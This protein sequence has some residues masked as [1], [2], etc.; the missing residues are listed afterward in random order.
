MSKYLSSC[1][2]V[3]AMLLCYSGCIESEHALSDPNSAELVPELMG[4]WIQV[5]PEDPSVW[6]IAAA[7]DGFPK[8]MHRL[9]KIENG[10]IEGKLFFVSNIGD[11]HYANIANFEDDLSLP[12]T[13]QPKQIKHYTLIQF[14]VKDGTAKLFEIEEA[15]IV[16]AIDKGEL[17]GRVLEQPDFLEIAPQKRL[18]S[19]TL[20]LQP[21]FSQN[22]A[23]L[24]GKA[25]LKYQK[26]K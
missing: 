2:V 4:T 1:L 24:T 10:R 25:W 26:Q 22:S 20:E 7:G 18:S 15:R 21:Y 8:G 3:L 6:T 14:D 17:K 16:A 13:W 5:P 23:Q 12:T 9:T 11:K 19:P